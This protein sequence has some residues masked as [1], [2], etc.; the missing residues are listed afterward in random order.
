M[1]N[2]QHERGWL[3]SEVWA[4]APYSE[5]EAWSW[6]IGEAAW[7][8]CAVNVKGHPVHVKRGSFTASLRF[9]AQKWQWKKDKVKRYLT[10]LEEWQM[11]KIETDSATGQ[12]VVSVCNYEKY[13]NKKGS[14]ETPNETGTRQGR[15][16][17]A[18]GAR[19]TRNPSNQSNQ[20]K[21]WWA[22]EV[23]K[24]NRKDYEDLLSR[25]SGSQESF[26]KWLDGRDVWFQKQEIPVQKNWFHSTSAALS[27]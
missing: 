18:T 2:Y 17:P 21:Y 13:Q 19:Q 27:A 25:Y 15:D 22:G 11:V 1:S 14:G 3:D 7:K 9:L 16:S 26:D 12:T 23:I 8:N 20:S 10:R 24:L 4:N 6:M 5:R